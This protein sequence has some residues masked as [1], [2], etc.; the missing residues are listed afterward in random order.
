MKMSSLAPILIAA[1]LS[2]CGAPLME[3]QK[4]S[5]TY[6]CR[7]TNDR[8]I[9]TPDGDYRYSIGGG[10]TLW[11][12]SYCYDT[13]PDQRT[14]MDAYTEK[15]AREQYNYRGN[16]LR[17][18]YAL[19]GHCYPD[20][21]PLWGD[22]YFKKPDKKTLILTSLGKER[23]YLLQSNPKSESSPRD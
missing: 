8:M 3:Q 7:A 11:P 22:P 13:P 16:G 9:F 21:K 18:T 6:L 20:G 10:E 23:Q 19:S 1:V 4:I 12:G 15:L 2:S 5:G 17:F 14:A